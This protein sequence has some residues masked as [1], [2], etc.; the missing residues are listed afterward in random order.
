MCVNYSFI[1]VEIRIRR[2][3][4]LLLKLRDFVCKFSGLIAAVNKRDLHQH[5]DG[6]KDKKN[7]L[8]DLHFVIPTVDV[9]RSATRYRRRL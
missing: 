1:F 7:S 3:G 5:D 6:K 9:R 4:S 8:G 2:C